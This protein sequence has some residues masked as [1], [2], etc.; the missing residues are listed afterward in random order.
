MSNVFSVVTLTSSGSK[1][2]SHNDRQGIGSK[3]VKSYGVATFLDPDKVSPKSCLCLL[4]FP[5]P[6]QNGR[7]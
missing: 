4:C 2:S 3:K 5:V 6:E 7:A 1:Y